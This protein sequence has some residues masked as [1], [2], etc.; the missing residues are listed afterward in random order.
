MNIFYLSHNI[1]ECVKWHFDSH[2]VKMPLEVAQMMCTNQWIF[3][4]FN[5]PM[6][7]L[8]AKALATLTSK[9]SEY[10]AKFAS[11]TDP[12]SR[13]AT[14]PA[15]YYPCHIN[16]PCTIWMRHSIE[17]WY[18][19]FCYAQALD[20]E[21]YFRFG[22]TK[23]SKSIDVINSLPDPDPKLFF[24]TK[25]TRPA[26]A[27]GDECLRF[28]DPALTYRYYYIWFKNHIAKWTNQPIPYWYTGDYFKC[29]QPS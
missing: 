2:V 26:E 22:K 4:T 12:S 16:H 7:K 9:T 6:G 11:S 19:S 18:W 17:N 28:D 3:H 20:A 25:F 29:K 23:V 8:N 24:E 5:R 14:H 10:K 13:V 1:D 21:R 27:V 15:P